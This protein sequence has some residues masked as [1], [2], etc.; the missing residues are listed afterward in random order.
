[1]KVRDLITKMSGNTE[2]LIYTTSK[3]CSM[4]PWGDC[5]N[6]SETEYDCRNCNAFIPETSE[7]TKY[8]GAV[9]YCPI[10]LAELSIVEINNALH[11]VRV[12]RTTKQ[13]HL[14]AIEVKD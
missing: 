13:K 3:G 10:K 8:H 11:D 4:P 6:G 9:E 14:I 12:K 1:M 7:F 2:I 5:A